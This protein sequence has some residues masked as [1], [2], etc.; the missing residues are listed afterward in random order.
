M[1]F[2]A[3][4][5]SKGLHVANT[6]RRSVFIHVWLNRMCCHGARTGMKVSTDHFTYFIQ[7]LP[8][9]TMYVKSKTPQKD[10]VPI[11]MVAYQPFIDYFRGVIIK[12]KKQRAKQASVADQRRRATENKVRLGP[13][14]TRH[15]AVASA[16][17]EAVNNADW[18]SRLAS[19]IRSAK[20]RARTYYLEDKYVSA[21]DKQERPSFEDWLKSGPKTHGKNMA[22]RQMQM[23]ELLQ[24]QADQTGVDAIMMAFKATDRDKDGRIG[25]SG[26]LSAEKFKDVIREVSGTRMQG[27][28]DFE[29]VYNMS[30]RQLDYCVDIADKVPARVPIWQWKD[31][32]GV[33]RDYDG[34][35]NETISNR[36]G[37]HR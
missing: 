21:L 30:P 16:V 18:G 17:L 15:D 14:P 1:R 26:C 24:S 29:G 13:P 35:S 11:S 19:D 23:V 25:V 28:N 33:W 3:L 10:M 31:N 36:T 6:E 32:Q 37:V 22:R 2:P 7:K 27:W 20:R 9:R 5:M 34:N 12:E 8:R 4:L